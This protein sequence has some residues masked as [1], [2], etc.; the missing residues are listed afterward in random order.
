MLVCK[1]CYKILD[2]ELLYG[3]TCPDITCFGELIQVD[4]LI[5]DA[6][7]LLWKKGYKSLACCSGHVYEK[8]FQCYIAFNV[9]YPK[10]KKNLPK[11][12]KWEE[13]T[14]KKS[15][16]KCTIERFMRDEW[17][18]YSFKKKI[19]IIYESNLELNKWVKKLP[20]LKRRK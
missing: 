19:K 1:S 3:Y 4:E 7:I 13:N 14:Y 17:S 18:D 20:N 11:N 9:F 5:A 2:K 10:L 16:I 8:S 12:F 6:I 15:F